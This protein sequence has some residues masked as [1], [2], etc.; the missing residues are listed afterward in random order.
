MYKPERN[1][2]GQ[3]WGHISYL[4]V[5]TLLILLIKCHNSDK[6][7]TLMLICIKSYKVIPKVPKTS[8]SQKGWCNKPTKLQFQTIFYIEKLNIYVDVLLILKSHLPAK[9]II[10]HL[11]KAIIIYLLTIPAR[12]RSYKGNAAP[13]QTVWCDTLEILILRILWIEIFSC[14][15]FSAIIL[16]NTVLF[17]LTFWSGT[18]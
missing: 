13:Y 14:L 12:S 10:M 5:T 1:F 4:N 6:T 15:E 2:W 11:K 3:I 8:W 17:L 16:A 9:S 7:M 18:V